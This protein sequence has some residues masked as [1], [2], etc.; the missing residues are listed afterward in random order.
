MDAV[1]RR[2]TGM[3]EAEVTNAD[4]KQP[5]P[6]HPFQE[7]ALA[8]LMLSDAYR[9]VAEDAIG[10]VHTSYDASP[11]A[12]G[13]GYVEEAA[14]LVRRAEE[15][16]RRAAIYEHERGTSWK[17]IGSALG[18]TKQSAHKRFAEHVDAWRAPLDQPDRVG[19]DGTPADERIPFGVRYTT[20][21]TVAYEADTAEYT[22][23]QLDKWLRKRTEPTDSWADEEHPVS[24]H[25]P[26]HTTTVMLMLTD[27]VSSQLR[28]D[29]M[30]PDPQAQADIC[31][32]RVALYERLLREGGVVPPDIHQWI[33]KE[34][35]RAAALRATPGR[36]VTWD[37]MFSN[38]EEETDQ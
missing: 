19:P 32:R 30:V 16:L 5:D 21:G 24:G 4:A 10:G 8:R 6:P 1:S 36:G 27:R 37:A 14:R 7:V 11:H 23:R 13:G 38:Q 25:L 20:D 12:G 9:D 33:E 31:D 15:V 34:R 26:R 2:L 35:A 22:A 3:T 29:Q 18:I 17:D 28:H